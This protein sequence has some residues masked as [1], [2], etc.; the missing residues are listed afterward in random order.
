MKQ[1][2]EW[3]INLA[4]SYQCPRCNV[5]IDTNKIMSLGVKES[6][7]YKGREV[8]FFEYFCENCQDSCIFE[9]DFTNSGNAIPKM[10]KFLTENEGD[11]SE[12]MEK[13]IDECYGVKNS[14]NSQ[15]SGI[16]DSEVK[17]IKSF[18]S[19]CKYWEDFLEE[20]GLSTEQIKKYSDIGQKE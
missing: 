14:K 16:T 17:G 1:V 11:S 7:K 9:L 5:P 2:P 13:I 18:L 15:K 19:S 10:L 8:A 4:K 6:H 3:L 12:E 20:I